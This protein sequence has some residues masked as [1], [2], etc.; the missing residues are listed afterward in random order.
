MWK[1]ELEDEI[2]NWWIKWLN[3]SIL[4]DNYRPRKLSLWLI[5]RIWIENIITG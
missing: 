2:I 5:L 3:L 1:L 4:E